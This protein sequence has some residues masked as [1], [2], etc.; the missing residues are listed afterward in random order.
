[1]TK[2]ASMSR[3]NGC[4]SSM[5]WSDASASAALQARAR[6][7]AD[8]ACS[9]CTASVG[10]RRET[11]GSESTCPKSTSMGAELVDVGE[12]VPADHPR[13]RQVEEDLA[14][15]VTGQRFPI[16]GEFGG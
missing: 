9:G 13:H 3:I 15:I 12:A 7:I 8:N 2:V 14:G 5:S 16:C 4:C 10:T 11:V 1:V 6:P